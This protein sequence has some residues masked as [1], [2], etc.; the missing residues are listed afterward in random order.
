MD[1]PYPTASGKWCKIVNTEIMQYYR[2]MQFRPRSPLRQA[3][4]FSQFHRSSHQSS[5]V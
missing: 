1:L 5:F 4:H 2:G 3:N